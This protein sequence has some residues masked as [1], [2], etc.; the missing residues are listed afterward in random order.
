MNVVT[1]L[2]HRGLLLGAC[3][4]ILLP[5]GEAPSLGGEGIGPVA[6]PLLPPPPDCLP[7][8]PP[9]PVLKVKVRIPA[10]A[11]PEQELTYHICIE[12]CSP[13]EAHHVLV[14]NALPANARFV[15]ADPPPSAMEPELQWQLGTIGGMAC[16][17]ITLVLLPTNK[18]DVK[19][20]T[21]V[22][23]EHGQCVVTRQAALVPPIVETIPPEVKPPQPGV[24]PPR[25]GEVPPPPQ[26]APGVKPP[27]VQPVPPIVTEEAPKLSL[28][29]EG[30]K[31]QYV[32]LPSRYFLTLSNTSKV[33]ATTVLIAAQ[34][35]DKAEFLSASEPGQFVRA[36]P[37]EANQVAWVLGALEPGA[38]RTV[39]LV[40]RASEPGEW[41]V[42]VNA[43][44][45]KGAN[46]QGEV[47]TKF[48]GVSALAI[49]LTDGAD[50]ILTGAHTSYVIPI[51]NPGSAAVTNLQL[52]ARVPPGLKLVRTRPEEHQKGENTPAGQWIIF[53][54]RGRLEPKG[55]DVYEVFVEAMR[56]GEQRFHVE[57]TADQLERERPVVE[58]ENT[59]VFED[60]KALPRHAPV[61]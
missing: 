2:L 34:L 3:A 17:E 20:C 35:P 31:Q 40:L 27:V 28:T 56:V 18:E 12:N 15:R 46:A 57:V 1:Y 16:R 38:R 45:D 42:K 32:N 6:G 23:F 10:L 55:A 37:P 54:P 13:A 26:P 9:P 5:W 8:D 47:C 36:K 30:H 48:L 22:Q 60:D 50:P 52:L 44:A 19:N 43:L 58:E 21:R 7:K 61:P 11:P 59:T 24:V 49:A 39:E 53:P 29:L 4:F 33:K 41:C 25:P 51:R 14:K